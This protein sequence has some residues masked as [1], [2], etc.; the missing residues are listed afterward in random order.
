MST[1]TQ[2]WRKRK[3]LLPIRPGMA[4]AMFL[5]LNM[6]AVFLYYRSGYGILLWLAYFYF[7]ATYCVLVIISQDES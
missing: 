4:A 1:L 7:S 3:G 5:E 2:I 6:L